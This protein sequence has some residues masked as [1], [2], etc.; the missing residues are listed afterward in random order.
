MKHAAMFRIDGVV[1]K[2]PEPRFKVS[3]E[4]L[5]V[6]QF[7]LKVEGWGKD[8]AACVYDCEAWGKA[9]HCVAGLSAGQAV[10]VEG[11]IVNEPYKGYDRIRFYVSACLLHAGGMVASQ[12]GGSGR[13]SDARRESAAHRDL[14]YGSA[15]TAPVEEDI[16]F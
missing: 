8:G 4:Q 9:K 6:L 5:E 2:A 15:Q 14:G 13:G 11:R 7:P 12:G 16:P 1:V 10:R 3:G